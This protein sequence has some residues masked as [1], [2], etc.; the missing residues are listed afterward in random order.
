MSQFKIISCKNP[1]LWYSKH[2][3]TVFTPRNEEKLSAGVVL[4]AYAEPNQWKDGHYLN[5]VWKDDCEQV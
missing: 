2:I 1:L 4:W 5:W 3:G